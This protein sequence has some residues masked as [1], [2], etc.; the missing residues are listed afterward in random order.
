MAWVLP[1]RHPALNVFFEAVTLLGY[2]L[3][4]ILFLSFGYHFWKS[5]IF[6]R[7]AL[8]VLL[9]GLLNTFLKDLLQDPRPAAE[10]ALD[11]RPGHSYGFPSGH[12]QGAVVLWGWLAIEA[13]R[14]WAAAAAVVVIALIAFSRLYLGV[15][16]VGDVFGGTVIGIACL[17]AWVA[18]VRNDSL[19]AVLRRSGWIPTA[20]VIV[21]LSAAFVYVYPAHERHPA[22]V[23]LLGFLL[24]WFLARHLSGN[25]GV[26]LTGGPAQKIVCAS[27]GAAAAFGALVASRVLG[28]TAVDAGAPEAPTT[29]AFGACVGL[30]V[31]WA[32]PLLL[33]TCRLARHE[34]P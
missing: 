1:L 5:S 10:F 6:Y 22:P 2:S 18:A 24:G 13:E 16:D 3:F 31:I 4:L 28:R 30:V 14:R 27:I 9:T 32:Y 19:Q 11:P 15:H 21:I 34:P 7:A 8:L 12:A 17:V 33:R 20:I 23:T 26:E 25:R 29:Y